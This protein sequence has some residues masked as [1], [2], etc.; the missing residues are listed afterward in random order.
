MKHE[1]HNLRISKASIGTIVGA[2][3]LA[4]A[5][6]SL[7]FVASAEMANATI[8]KSAPKSAAADRQRDAMETVIKDYLL[9]NPAIVR[10]A[11]QTLERREAETKIA[12][13]KAAVIKNRNALQNNAASPVSGNPQGDVTL[14]EFFDYRCGFCQRVAPAVAELLE[15]DKNVRVIYKDL[16]I[17]GPDSLLSAKAALAAERQGKH[18]IFHTLLLNAETQNEESIKNI[19]SKVGLDVAKLMI[20]MEDPAIAKQIEENSRIAGELDIQGTPAF[21]LG[22]RVLPGAVDLESMVRLVAAERTLQQEM[23]KLKT[24]IVPTPTKTATR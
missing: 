4:I 8:S 14:I 11:L 9:K 21:V 5:T 19:A 2:T 3:T 20:D 17:L 7:S 16:P 18:G 10:E 22:D 23:K 13:V 1:S 24:A 6:L 12:E 15:R